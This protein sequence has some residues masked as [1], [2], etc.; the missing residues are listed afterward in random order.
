VGS[1]DQLLERRELPQR[2]E[3]RIHPQAGPGQIVRHLD[4]RLEQLDRLVLAPDHHVDPDE[5]VDLEE[6]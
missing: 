5:L 3:R 2:I 6:A 1:G 4:Q